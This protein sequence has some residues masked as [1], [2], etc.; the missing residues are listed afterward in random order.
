MFIG[1]QPSAAAGAGDEQEVATAAAVVRGDDVG[2]GYAS[3]AASAAAASVKPYVYR[4]VG[5]HVFTPS[6]FSR[7]KDKGCSG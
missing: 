7:P 5:N 6:R 2:K 3:T 1:N 4:K